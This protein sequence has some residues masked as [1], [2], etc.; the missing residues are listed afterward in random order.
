MLTTDR[1]MDR[2]D[3]GQAVAIVQMPVSDGFNRVTR[4]ILW[5]QTDQQVRE[6]MLPGQP[7]CRG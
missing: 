2:K 1:K 7:Y 5:R 6:T 3:F 4:R